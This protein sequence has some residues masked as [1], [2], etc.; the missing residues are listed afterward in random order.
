[1][2][3]NHHKN[4][5]VMDVFTK[6]DRFDCKFVQR[7]TRF[8]RNLVRSLGLYLHFMCGFSMWYKYTNVRK[9]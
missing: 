2:F 1:M 9:E 5:E 3:E 6:I 8:L 7:L 4:S